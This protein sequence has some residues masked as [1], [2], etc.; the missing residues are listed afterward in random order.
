[1]PQREPRSGFG[2]NNILSNQNIQR[3][4]G[5][6]AEVKSDALRVGSQHGRWID[7][8]RAARWPVRRQRHRTANHD[9]TYDKCPGIDHRDVLQSDHGAEQRHDAVADDQPQCG[10][11]TRKPQLMDKNEAPDGRGAC[12]ERHSDADLLRSLAEGVRQDPIQARD[13]KR[14]RDD[15]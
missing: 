5:S 2:K 7:A 12:A 3:L 6:T 8:N 15:A 4:H 1:M 14:Q 10:S 13:A 11:S 9:E